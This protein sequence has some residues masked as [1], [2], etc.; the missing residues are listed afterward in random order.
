MI[1]LRPFQNTFKGK[2]LAAWQRVQ[3]VL[4]VLP[5]GGGKTVVFSSIIRDHTGAAAAVVHR[6]EIIKQISLSLA[7]LGV[8]HRII[9]PDD[10][11]RGA[12]RL[13]LKKLGKSFVDPNA[14]VGVAS[15]QTL[16]S[17]SAGRNA[18][19]QRWAKQVTLA[20]YDEGHH[21]VTTGQWAKSIEI[22]T[23]ARRLFV[24]ATPERADGKGLGV[25]ADG[26][27]EEMVVGPSTQWLI[28]EGFLTPFKYFA[29]GSDLNME[30]A[31]LGASGDF[32]HQLMRKRV[33]ESH[34]VGDVVAHYFRF[35]KGLRTIV[36]ATDVA[37]AHEIATAF[38]VAGVEAVALSG[39]TD[40][41]E[42]DRQLERFEGGDL[43]VLINVDLFDEGFDVPAVECVIQARPTESLAKFLQM[44][45]RALRI[46]EGKEFAVVIDAVRNWERHGMPNWARFWT[47]DGRE[48]R[49]GKSDL[50]PQKLCK[51][52]SQVYEAF[53]KLCPYQLTP[54]C[55]KPELPEVGA[56]RGI[57]QVEGDLQELDV[58][59][60]AELYAKINAAD[61]SDDEYS[62]QLIA[63]NVPRQGR[64]RMLRRHQEAKYRRQ[65]LREQVAWWVGMQ[66]DGRPLDEIHRRFFHRFGID[67]ATAFTLD[68]KK[69][70]QLIEVI[71]EK[72]TEDLA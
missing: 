29:P 33:V 36:F 61:S 28:D 37:T 21:Y 14:P 5:T 35:A 59:A 13:H 38:C 66:P 57:E 22:F 23:N 15:V 4:A 18:A 12:R 67:I 49:G 19:I 50:A 7:K 17:K 54:A 16:T 40:A 24:T 42:R 65:V 32:T 58:A 48:K 11:I 26:F 46:L 63:R 55:A 52:C 34:L 31:T 51:G 47:L 45:G 71:T 41:G 43:T 9:A 39:E 10:V 56:V 25:H 1:K 72:F 2:I 3:S 27:A 69:T 44:I 60:L 62:A 53:H 70:D 20:V 6:K 8:K 68:A 64:P 30:G